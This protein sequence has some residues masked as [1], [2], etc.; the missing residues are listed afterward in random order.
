MSKLAILPLLITTLA[1]A[2]P[3][4]IELQALLDPPEEAYKLVLPVSVEG[5]WPAR[6]ELQLQFAGD[7]RAPWVHTLVLAARGLNLWQRDANGKDTELAAGRWD[8]PPS[9]VTIERN[10]RRF[11]VLVGGAVVLRAWL[12]PSTG[13][14]STGSNNPAIS[15]GEPLMQATEYLYFA[16]D[17]MRAAEDDGGWQTVEGTWAPSGV[18]DEHARS[19]EERPVATFSAN[20]FAY[21]ASDVTETALAT[22]GAWFWDTYRVETSVRPGEPLGPGAAIGLRGQATD[23][24]NYLAFEWGWGLGMVRQLVS[25]VG[26]QR[27]VLAEAPGSWQADQWYRLGLTLDDGRAVATVDG[28]P[29][30]EA[31]YVAPSQGAV[32]LWA[33]EVSF[34]DYDDVTV[35][36]LDEINERFTRPTPGMWLALAGDWRDE[37][38]TPGPDGRGA[39]TIRAGGAGLAL[40]REPLSD[41]G[42]IRSHVRAPKG[43]AVG[44]ATGVQGPDEALQVRWGDTMRIVRVSGGEA[45]VLA[46]TALPAPRDRWAELT[47]REVGE[48]AEVSVDGQRVLAAATPGLRA[49]QRGLWGDPGARFSGCEAWDEQERAAEFAPEVAAQFATDSYMVSWAKPE[50]AWLRQG[51]GEPNTWLWYR[52]PCWGDVELVVDAARVWQGQLQA[53]RLSLA[54]AEQTADSG[55]TLTVAQREPT[56]GSVTLTLARAGADVASAEADLAGAALLRFVQRGKLFTVAADDRVLLGWS[57]P[58]QLL[59]GHQ[60]GL[61]SSAPH[62]NFGQ[63][64]VSATNS[65]DTT[66][67]TAPWEWWQGKGIW[68]TTNRWFCDPRW[69]FF[70]GHVDDNPVIWSKQAYSGDM[71]LDTYVGLRMGAR[72]GGDD[73]Y[74]GSDLGLAIAGDGADLTSGYS[75]L[76]AAEGN[77]KSVLLRK[78]QVMAVNTDAA[79]RFKYVGTSGAALDE[80][81]RHWF[82]MVMKRVGNRII[83]T[84]DDV[85][86]FDV[87]DPDPLP[88]GRVALYNMGWGL[89]V[90]RLRIGYEGLTD[91]PP[92]PDAAAMLASADRGAAL[93][94][95]LRNDFETGLGAVRAVDHPVTS[96]VSR[97]TV[98]DRPGHVLAMTNVVAGG[99]RHVRL[100][101]AEEDGRLDLSATPQLKFAYRLPNPVRVNIYLALANGT[102]RYVPFNMGPQTDP[103]FTEAGLKLATAVAAPGPAEADNRWHDFSVDLAAVCAE[104][105]INPASDVIGIDV[106]MLVENPYLT[107][108]WT[109]NP[110]GSTWYLDDLR[111]EPAG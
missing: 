105:G 6:G 29:V 54:G 10:G 86:V 53:L 23:T 32:G 28:Q 12:D 27:T 80:F 16:D 97:A 72:D 85:V 103:L 102:Y 81:H 38:G 67:G 44:L 87:T 25:V 7:A 18:S 30:L 55:Y 90:A 92:L 111:L 8:T 61:A 49:G 78:G 75:F 13:S 71:S 34:A 96:L 47:L 93:P 37:A 64:Q 109:G 79:G 94:W 60:I 24:D 63:I 22:V 46:E 2:A 11:R 9:S 70:G 74:H 106:G 68:E 95:G 15:F 108:G 69:S 101:E 110:A 76:F 50:G 58:G 88:G 4:P 89:N 84:I 65:Y 3:A 83:C 73:R 35:L 31:D 17:F 66:F 5:A 14:L 41:S 100:L 48:R 77:T 21:R 82:H 33:R 104:A 52:Y 36:A 57:E 40:L 56:P 43:G 98:A 107:A 62:F 1:F 91:G 42:V 26:G 59:G 51:W 19:A 20:P 39:K 45:T 99:R